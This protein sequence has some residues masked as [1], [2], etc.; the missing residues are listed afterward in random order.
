[1]LVACDTFLRLG[2]SCCILLVNS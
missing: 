1:M 2:F